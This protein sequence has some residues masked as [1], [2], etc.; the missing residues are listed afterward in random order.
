MTATVCGVNSGKGAGANNPNPEKAAVPMARVVI[1]KTVTTI[2]DR[3]RLV[4]KKIAVC[5]AR[6]NNNAPKGKI[7]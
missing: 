3:Q 5:S 2:A 7:P 6:V 1:P 4:R